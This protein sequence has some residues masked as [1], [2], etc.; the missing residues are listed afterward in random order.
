MLSYTISYM[1][2]LPGGLKERKKEDRII[3]ALVQLD[4]TDTHMLVELRNL[5]EEDVKVGMR[6]CAVW[7]DEPKGALSDISHFIPVK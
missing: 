2:I 4:G 7:V 5:F 6:I 3:Y 1:E